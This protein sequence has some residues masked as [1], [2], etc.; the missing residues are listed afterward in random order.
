[1]SALNNL[2]ID[3][4]FKDDPKYFRTISKDEIF[5]VPYGMKCIIN[6]ADSN[7]PGTHWVALD[8]T[9]RG[10]IT[11]F[12]SFGEICPSLIEQYMRQRK[13]KKKIYNQLVIQSLNSNKCGYFCIFVLTHYPFIDAI[14]AL[15]DKSLIKRIVKNVRIKIKKSV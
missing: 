9:Q 8:D 13:G 3:A 11:Y 15:L 14:N 10:I 5:T 1:M 4:Y 6:L 12:D 7:L 2:E